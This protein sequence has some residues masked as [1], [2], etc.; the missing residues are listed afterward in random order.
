VA[1]SLVAALLITLTV[2]ASGM[3][4][5]GIVGEESA[6][7]EVAFEDQTAAQIQAQALTDM[8]EV[9]SAR[10]SGEITQSGAVTTIDLAQNTLGACVGTLS[11]GGGQAQMIVNSEGQFLKGDRLF[12]K[13]V[14]GS[15]KEAKRIK[16]AVG[17]KWAKM[18]EGRGGFGGFCTLAGLLAAFEPVP[19]NSS[20][21]PSGSQSAAG[22]ATLGGQ[23]VI[24]G[25]AAVELISEASTPS[26]AWV[27]TTAPHRIVRLDTPESVLDFSDFNEP[28]RAD[29]PP[30]RQVIDFTKL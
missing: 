19:T 10:V 3:V 26:S 24:A 5:V 7:A 6:A 1:L 25:E 30:S 21:S 23:L 20:E 4:L 13:A 15:G 12:W 18:P 22:T 2:T 8:A 27:A 14:V 17:D 28:V 29:S 16:S 11:H 9:T